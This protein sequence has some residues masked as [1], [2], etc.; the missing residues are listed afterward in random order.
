[1]LHDELAQRPQAL[2]QGR[3]PPVLPARQP[4]RDIVQAPLHE[5]SVHFE[6]TPGASHGEV[7]CLGLL[8]SFAGDQPACPSDAHIVACAPHWANANTTTRRVAVDGCPG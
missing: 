1:M 3:L 7:V 2:A 8:H 4:R 6:Q 5:L